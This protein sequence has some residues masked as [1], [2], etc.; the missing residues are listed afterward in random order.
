MPPR[1]QSGVMPP[2]S[3]AQRRYALPARQRLRAVRCVVATLT[4]WPA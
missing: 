4:A 3:K 2:Q 1:S